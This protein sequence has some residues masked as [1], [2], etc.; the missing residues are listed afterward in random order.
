MVC[1]ALLFFLGLSR[2]END[3]KSPDAVPKPKKFFKSRNTEPPD[4]NTSSYSKSPP[5][6][7]P[8]KSRLTYEPSDRTTR[9]SSPRK[10][11]SSKTSTTSETKTVL[12]SNVN[13]TSSESSKP[14][15]VLR[16]CRGKSQL[17][18]D[19]DESESTPT[20]SSTP[21]TSTVT[22]PRALRETSRPAN[23]RITRSAR[24]SMQQDPSSSPATAD[25]PGEFSLFMSPKAEDDLSPVYIPAEKYELERK[26]MYD[27]LL[28]PNS[29]KNE[30]PEVTENDISTVEE[31]NVAKEE[32]E[33]QGEK[34]MELEE[35]LQ[36]A[37]VV[38]PLE[39]EG[40]ADNEEEEEETEE[41]T[42]V[43]NIEEV[44]VPSP[45]QEVEPEAPNKNVSIEEEWSTDT[46]SNSTAPEME[47]KQI[48]PDPNYTVHPVQ[49]EKEEIDE[50]KSPE[51][52]P[53]VKLVI[54][55]KKGS[56]F[57]SR[58]L[59]GDNAS[60]KRRALYRHK[61]TD[62]NKEVDKEAAKSE[63]VVEGDNNTSDEFGFKDSPL[64]RI[65]KDSSDGEVASVKVKCDKGDKPVSIFCSSISL[66]ESSQVIIYF[67]SLMLILNYFL[68]LYCCTK[69]QKSSSNPRNR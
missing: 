16:I 57:K 43:N 32:C 54:S 64:E 40:I 3:A 11:F 8:K 67:T 22:S 6:S 39:Q 48:I 42:E 1:Y 61:W 17:L 51:P 34:D 14:P 31:N 53:P 38:A 26:A 18:N 24:R 60:K 2:S 12:S 33:E 66:Q 44:N 19:S 45:K 47:V 35:P 69:R 23:C 37:E 25:T 41:Q 56:I 49:E 15:I 4:L 55:K 5:Y 27:N 10:F 9:S 46:D 7:P 29:P 58:T 28:K 21:S 68:V 65:E 63:E 59:V 52:A 20:P 13:K 62:D 36:P 30:E 50:E